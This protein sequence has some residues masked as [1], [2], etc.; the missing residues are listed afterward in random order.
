M[1]RALS[2]IP[3]VLVLILA[4]DA[5]AGV[6]AASTRQTF[7]TP[8]TTS[9]NYLRLDDA[10]A[11]SLTFT[12]P[13]TQTVAITYSTDCKVA[14]AG[15]VVAVVIYVDGVAIAGTGASSAGSHL[16]ASDIITAGSRTGFITVGPG[17][18]TLQIT[19]Q[20]LGSGT[21]T[22]Y[23]TTTTVLN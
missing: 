5:Q 21:G 7:T 19:G 20:V 16:C 2:L 14:T 18:H 23:R 9:L 4:A 13:T 6:L 1:K 17:T 15:N 11:T 22:L 10:G 12:T 8:I 3:A